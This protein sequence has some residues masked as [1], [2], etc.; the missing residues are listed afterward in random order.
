MPQASKRMLIAGNWK[1]HG[2]LESA[3]A[4]AED[5]AAAIRENEALRA[6]DWL[7]CPPF[8]HL[9]VVAAA[10]QRSADASSDI[11]ALAWSARQND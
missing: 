7:I 3:R 1:M 11:N 6:V 9:P 4:L 10:L 2:R 8:V 5:I